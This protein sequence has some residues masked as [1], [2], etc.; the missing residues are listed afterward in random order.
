VPGLGAEA[1][2]V[3]AVDAEEQE[4]EEDDHASRDEQVDGFPLHLVVVEVII[5]QRPV[6]LVGHSH[7]VDIHHAVGVHSIPA[8]V[9]PLQ[10]LDAN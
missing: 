5:V 2:A 8:I 10:T 1:V 6:V 3:A 9:A 4:A 7:S